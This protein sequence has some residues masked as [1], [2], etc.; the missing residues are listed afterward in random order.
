MPA[1]K[2][3]NMHSGHRARMKDKF[4]LYGPRIFHTYELLEMLLY[5]AV[6][7]KDTNPIAKRLLQRFSSLDGILLKDREELKTVEGIGDK[8]AELIYRLGRAGFDF[9]LTENDKASDALRVKTAGEEK[10]FKE[11]S[12]LTDKKQVKLSKLQEYVMSKFDSTDKYRVKIFYFDRDMCL[13]FIQ[14]FDGVDYG[15]A[16]LSSCEIGTLAKKLG[17]SYVVTAHT[18]PYGPLF[19]TESDLQTNKALHQSLFSEGVVLYEHFVIS[20]SGISPLMNSKP[21]FVRDEEKNICEESLNTD[22][23]MLSLLEYTAKNPDLA[24]K[25]LLE[26]YGSWF[27]V[28]EANADSVAGALGGDFKTSQFIKLALAIV[29]RRRTDTFKFAKRHS[30]NEILQYLASELFALENECVYLVTKDDTG[31]VLSCDFA[32]EGDENYSNVFPSKL[33][34]II[35]KRGANALILAHNHPGGSLIASDDDVA[36]TKQLGE[37]FKQNSVSL[38]KHYVFADFKYR[39]I[40]T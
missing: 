29:K 39:E 32:G 26:K 4:A 33:L 20:G 10:L 18:H 38:L 34:S 17:A 37:F 14:E 31:R 27:R 35:K 13:I 24:I 7:Y 21:L 5:Y 2:K 36:S 16:A 25:L 19:A 30:E 15:S 28:F 40:S 9:A 8:A 6:P 12:L 1:D 11:A 23:I 3:P 22:R